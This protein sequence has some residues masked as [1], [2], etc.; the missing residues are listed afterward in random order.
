MKVRCAVKSFRRVKVKEERS[1]R[2]IFSG[3]FDLALAQ[4]LRLSPHQIQD[5]KNGQLY[6]RGIFDGGREVFEGGE[7]GVGSVSFPNW[8][9][10]ARRLA[11]IFFRA[12]FLR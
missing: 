4:H 9:I 10:G 1:R 3:S 2:G 7:S 6:E 12:S 5:Q 8:F 11:P